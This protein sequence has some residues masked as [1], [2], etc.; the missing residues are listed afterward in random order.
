MKNLKLLNDKK[1]SI[2]VIFLSIFVK[3]V[4]ANEPVDIWNTQ[5]SNKNKIENNEQIENENNSS[6]SI[7]INN[8]TEIS[9]TKQL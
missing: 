5:D 8:S 9:Y 3:N 4:F 1:F 2:L 6:S 7:F